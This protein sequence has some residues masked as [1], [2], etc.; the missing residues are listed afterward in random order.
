MAYWINGMKGKGWLPHYWLNHDHPRVIS[1]Y[2]DPEHH[3]RLSGSLLGTILLTLPGTP[4]IYNGEEIGMTNVDYDHIDD[5]Q[6][7]WVKNNAPAL[8]KKYPLEVVLR[9]LRR[10]SR[11]N[12]RTPM[13]WTDGLYAGFS[14]VE[15]IQKVN[16]NADWLN[17]EKQQKDDHSIL[18]HYRKLIH[19]RKDPAYQETL[20]FGDFA[21]MDAHN[22]DV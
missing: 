18:N 10:T 9:H 3:H 1:H 2:G 20:V 5:F 14:T 11:D 6:D 12:A 21:L 15:P 22:P 17:V 4:F 8:L 16:R 19:L 13:Q 7:V